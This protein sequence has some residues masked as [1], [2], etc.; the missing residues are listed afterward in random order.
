[1][2]DSLE[3]EFNKET[4]NKTLLG[5]ILRRT[6]MIKC[7]FSDV[8]EHDMD[9]LFMEE[10]ICSNEFRNLFTN[11]VGFSNAR[12]LSAHSSKRDPLYGESD[13]TVILESAGERIGL[14]IEDKI[15]A[16]AMPE[17]ATRYFLRGD[18][19]IKSGEYGQFFVFIVAPRKYLIEN[20]EAHKYP[21]KIEYETV[22]AYFEQLNDPRSE[23]KIQQIRKAIEKQKKGYQVDADNAVTGFWRKYSEQQKKHYPGLLLLY[24]GEEKGSNATWIRFNTV[25][26]GLYMYHKAEAGFVDM[27]F[28]GCADRIVALEGLLAETIGDYL[29]D[30]FT[31]Q[32]TGKA[33]AIRLI[34]PVLDMHIPFENQIEKTNACLETVK[35]M[36]DF[37]KSLDY[38]KTRKLLSKSHI[39][40]EI[41]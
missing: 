11:Q 31:V 30:G 14:L 27:T 28:D 32:R 33:A 3:W 5:T 4:Q 23:F 18:K 41:Q 39:I 6:Q 8:S 21:N 7:Y 34:V 26:P 16:I 20:S 10:F 2:N 13:I 19:G 22:L 9:M 29:K 40:G 38:T 37:A 12:I 24:N 1:M 25:I 35:K 15:D 17:Q 36:S